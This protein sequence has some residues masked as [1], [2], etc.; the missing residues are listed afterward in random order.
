[1][2]HKLEKL[3]EHCDTVGR[4]FDEI[5]K[6]RLGRLIVGETSQEVAS[7]VQRDR[8]PGMSKE[9]YN[10]MVTYGTPE[11]VIERIQELVDAG[12]QYL[13]FNLGYQDEERILKVFAEKV[14]PQV[15][16]N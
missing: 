14:M 16:H 7:M 13:I 11:Q 2:R 15:K 3:R 6:T 1:M 5:L 10:E 12:I 4:D 9:Q 8:R